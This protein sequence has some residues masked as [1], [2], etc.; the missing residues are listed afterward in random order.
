MDFVRSKSMG[1]GSAADLL[2]GAGGMGEQVEDG[3]E[4]GGVAEHV[5]VMVEVAGFLDIVI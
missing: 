5:G 3:A 2:L 4:G 1:C